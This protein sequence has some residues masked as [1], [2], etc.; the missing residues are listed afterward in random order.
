VLLHGRCAI[1]RPTLSD[2]YADAGWQGDEARGDAGDIRRIHL[3]RRERS[4][5]D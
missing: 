3:V 5:H 2:A 1:A 4:S